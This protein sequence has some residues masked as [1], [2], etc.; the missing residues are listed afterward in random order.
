[1]D[2]H[3][4]HLN[5]KKIKADEEGKIWYYYPC[6]NEDT[7]NVK[8]D[9][10]FY[11][12]IAVSEKEWETLIELDR[13]EYNN[14]HKETRRKAY[15]SKKQ[16]ETE[17]IEKNTT[18][19]TPS[20]DEEVVGG[21][22]VEKDISSL[23]G[24]EKQ[25]AELS[26]KN[27]LKQADIAKKLGVT[28][29][30]VSS[31]LKNIKTKLEAEE[32]DE[33]EQLNKAWQQIIS[34][35]EADNDYDMYLELGIR[36]LNSDDLFIFMHWFYSFGELCKNIM[37]CMLFHEETMQQEIDEYKKTA[38]EREL[39]HFNE[40]YAS[41][42][43]PIQ[44]MYIRMKRETE[45]RAEMFKIMP[46]GKAYYRLDE[47]VDKIAKRVNMTAEEFVYERFMKNFASG[48]IKRY[49]KFY[50]KYCGTDMPSYKK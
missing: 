1:M 8:I 21:I 34:K 7:A 49:N 24:K 43:P 14:Q 35:G 12:A 6:E 5:K 31:T 22:T 20:I 13:L 23:K 37:R 30:Y 29:G 44:I 27:D 28:Q 32:K 33:E 17:Y 46:I 26:F 48:R 36:S 39:K 45:R 10:K 9:G 2:K 50:K 18:D 16:D 4:Y 42:I 19:L 25:I 11:Y 15:I 40:N 47:T 3:A 38:S 41:N